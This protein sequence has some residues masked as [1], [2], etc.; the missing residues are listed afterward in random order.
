MI[1]AFVAAL[2]LAVGVGGNSHPPKPPT[3]S[4]RVPDGVL[5]VIW[6]E[7][8]LA[9]PELSRLNPVLLKPFGR[10]VSLRVGG[11]SATA[12]S[13]SGRLLASGDARPG[14]Q[15]IDTGSMRPV[16]ALKLAATGWVTFL[17]WQ[18]G[19]L[20]AV[21]E[22]E[23]SS[24]VILVDPL[25]RQVLRRHRFRR[26]IL[27]VAEGPGTVV[28]LTGPRNRIG[29]VELAVVGA[30][31]MGSVVVWAVSGG[32]KA[33]NDDDGFRARQVIPGLAIDTDALRAVVVPAGKTVAEVSLHDLSV[34]YHAL[35]EPVSLL[36]RLRNWLEPA[37]E[38][39]LLAGPQRKAAWLGN[40]L[41]A[42]TGADYTTV[43]NSSGNPDVDV[44]AAGL[45]LIDTSDWSIRKVD[46][47]TSD[48]NVFPSSLLAFGETSWGDPSK[49]GVGL[50]GYDLRG[51]KIFHALDGVRVSWVDAV[52]GLAYVSLDNKVYTVVDAATGRILARPKARKPLSLV[53]N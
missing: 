36:G 41:V 17:S 32:S 37:A 1:R 49:A 5:G 24:A 52:G 15:F 39:K 2:A 34:T 9:R 42:V 18:R 10:S 35:A 20:F 38:A 48:F 4:A 23:A 21:V 43:T 13:P 19:I 53:T 29:P 51:E 6:N 16:G 46:D 27:S 33:E 22:D 3:A 12:F 26:A 28:L 50:A 31:G 47:E 7:T 40:G 30:K 25:G 45:S 44:R 8:G 11:G 14:V